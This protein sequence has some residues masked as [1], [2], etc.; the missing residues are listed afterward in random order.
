MILAKVTA[1]TSLVWNMLPS[2]MVSL[3][4]L[5]ETN[6]TTATGLLAKK[7]LLSN[8]NKSVEYDRNVILNNFY[9][10]WKSTTL[11]W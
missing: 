1:D 11:K 5:T 3:H 2:L 7:S 6:L 10:L 4:V 9:T 8:Y